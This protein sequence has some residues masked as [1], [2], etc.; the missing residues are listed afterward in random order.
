MLFAVALT[1]VLFPPGVC[2][3]VGRY[4]GFRRIPLVVF[5]FVSFSIVSAAATMDV[6]FL[7]GIATWEVGVS[8]IDTS[9]AVGEDSSRSLVAA[10]TR[11]CRAVVGEEES[12]SSLVELSATSVVSRDIDW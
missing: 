7:C 4:L 3:V 8:S 12:S 1:V 11:L 10:S 6:A 5:G 9:M 2:V